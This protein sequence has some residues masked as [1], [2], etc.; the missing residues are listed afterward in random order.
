VTEWLALRFEERGGI[1]D[2]VDDDIDVPV[3]VQVAV[4][5]AAR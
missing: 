5:R 4:S 3:A 1:I 2:L